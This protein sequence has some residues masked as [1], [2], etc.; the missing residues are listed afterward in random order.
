MWWRCHWP[1]KHP[2]SHNNK[3]NSLVAFVDANI[4][5]LIKMYN[6][7]GCVPNHMIPILI[8]D[9]NLGDSWLSISDTWSKNIVI[10]ISHVLLAHSCVCL[11]VDSCGLLNKPGILPLN[12][13]EELLKM[14]HFKFNAVSRDSY[15]K[16]AWFISFIDFLIVAIFAP[17]YWLFSLNAMCPLPIFITSIKFFLDAFAPIGCPLP[18]L[19]SWYETFGTLKSH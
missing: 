18:Q 4:H 13:F 9:N 19:P 17:S 16:C 2:V 12:Y 10:P 15:S 1:C 14:R 7:K 11:T 3:Y 6:L 8:W 5:R